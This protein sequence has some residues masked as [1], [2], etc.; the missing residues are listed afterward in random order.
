MTITIVA[1]HTSVA[2]SMSLRRHW[3]LARRAR[4]SLWAPHW[5]RYKICERSWDHTYQP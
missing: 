3:H 1:M 4:P 5:C 2:V